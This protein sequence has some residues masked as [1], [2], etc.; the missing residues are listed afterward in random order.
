MERSR[1]LLA[2]AVSTRT[3]EKTCLDEG[4]LDACIG[5]KPSAWL[6]G[7]ECWLAT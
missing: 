2:P 6:A 7:R 4:M 5:M 1:L 3:G